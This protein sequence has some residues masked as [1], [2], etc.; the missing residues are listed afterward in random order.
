MW[1]TP[2]GCVLAFLSPSRIDTEW[3]TIII[4]DRILQA[5]LEEVRIDDE[6]VGTMK[7]WEHSGLRKTRFRIH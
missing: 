7:S 1:D 5:L 3:M 6:P 2:H 4:C